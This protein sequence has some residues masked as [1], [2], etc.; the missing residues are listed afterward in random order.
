MMVKALFKFKYLIL[1][2]AI[3]VLLSQCKKDNT[4]TPPVI[5]DVQFLGHKGGGN[6]TVN[7]STVENTIPAIQNGLKTMTGI[8]VDVQM[9]LD[10]TIWVFHDS[11]IASTSCSAIAHKAIILSTDAE[12][13]KFTICSAKAQDRIYRLSE[14]VNYWHQ[15][16]TP[17]YMSLHIK[18]DFPA[19]SMNKPAIGGEALYLSKFADNLAKIIPS[20]AV[21]GKIMLEVYDATFCTKIHKLI[22]GIKVCLIKEVTFPKQIND[23]IALGYD[24][25][26]CIFS[27]PTLTSDEV[28]RAQSKGLIVELWTPDTKQELTTAFGFHP[29]FIQTNNLNVMS[30]L[31][32]TVK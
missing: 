5:T 30:L 13:A 12:I 11:D 24:G 3:L 19:D 17:F 27:E 9:S 4:T 32:V 29:N 16:S 14:I 18:L 21:P 7:P 26:S 15:A 31:N 25:V 20:V 8:E 10:G 1:T 6:S 28:I 22:S 23:A 2:L